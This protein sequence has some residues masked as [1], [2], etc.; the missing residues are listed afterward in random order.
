MLPEVIF[1]DIDMPLMDG[2][3]FLDEFAKQLKLFVRFLVRKTSVKVS[4]IKTNDRV[5]NIELGEMNFAL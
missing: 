4:S 3:Q 2:F 1:L 5:I